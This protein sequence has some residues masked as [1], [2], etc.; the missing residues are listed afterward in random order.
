MSLRQFPP[1]RIAGAYTLSSERQHHYA[2]K[3]AIAAVEYCCYRVV[4]RI[5]AAT[6]PM[7]IFDC[8]TRSGGTPPGH[9]TGSHNGG[10]DLDLG[11]YGLVDLRPHGY[12]PGPYSNATDRMTGPPDARLF[13]ARAEVE[14]FL[15]MGQLEDS[16]QGRLVRLCA[17]D[18]Y[19]DRYLHP[20]IQTADAR[21]S[22][23]AEALRILFSSEDGGWAKY[24]HH[25]RHLRLSSLQNGDEIARRIERAFIQPLLKEAPVPE[26]AG[27]DADDP[28]DAPDYKF[29]KESEPDGN[30]G[31]DEPAGSRT[32]RH[33]GERAKSERA[34]RS[35]RTGDSVGSTD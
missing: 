13:A 1:P 17:T 4:R 31:S 27:I 22:V 5:G 8:A 20:K 24:H 6:W 28:A 11:Y 26:I 29:M 9:P 7:R 16:L 2:E 15:A 33:R 35:R 23:K 21:S 19:I 10:D 25:H 14:W 12:V 3:Y 32:K 34:R 30:S 18:R